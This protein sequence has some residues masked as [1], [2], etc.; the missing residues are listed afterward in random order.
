MLKI[1]RCFSLLLCVLCVLLLFGC[2]NSG[3]ASSRYIKSGDSV[4]EVSVLLSDSSLYT[5]SKKKSELQ[6]ISRTD[7]ASLYFGE[8]NCSVSLYEA[9]SGKLWRSLPEKYVDGA[10]CVISLGVIID[11][12][13]YTLDSQSDSL[14]F[15]TA[16]YEIRDNG[17]LVTY[18]FRRTIEDGTKLD[19]TVP[20]EFISTDGT[21]VA[22]IDCQNIIGENNGDNVILRSISLLPYFGSY[23]SGADGDFILLPDGCGL[24]LDTSEYASE[25]ESFSV[26]VYGADPSQNEEAKA[27]AIIPAFG[28]K[29]GSNSFTAVIDEGAEIA[30]VKAERASKESGYN[31]VYAEFEITPTLQNDDGSFYVSESTYNGK[32]KLSYRFLSGDNANYIGM[33]SA[34]RE[35]LIRSGDLV[36]DNI[37]TSSDYPFNLNLLGYGEVTDENGKSSSQVLCDFSQ[38][39]DILSSLKAKDINNINLRYKAVFEGG[40]MQKNIKKADVNSS[41]GTDKQL[42]ELC[43]YAL[44]GSATIYPDI[45][46]ITADSKNGFN[47]SALA[48]DGAET[49][50]HNSSFG[51]GDFEFVCAESI[52]DNTK[53]MLSYLRDS[54]FEGVCLSDAGS[55]LY[56]DFNQS[57]AAFRTDTAA[58]IYEQSNA[59]SANKKLMTN[60]GFLYSIKYASVIVGLPQY[61]S[62]RKNEGASQVPFIQAILHGISDYSMSPINLYS[63][64]T[65]AFLKAVEY[66]GIPYYEWYHTDNGTEEEKDSYYYMNSIAD[67]QTNYERMKAT[68]SDLRGARI[69]DHRQVEKNVYVTEYDG[70]TLIYVN[71]NNKAV[72][73][74][75]VTVD[76]KSFIR[77]N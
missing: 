17:V 61:A 30:T 41:L 65:N 57:S 74:S 32:I 16:S 54:D 2:G 70:S 56:S 9:G 6:Q 73:V 27:T 42:Q 75:G 10:P 24:T 72:T 37:D 44:S 28:L 23:S 43:D 50:L 46:L 21:M 55:V 47:S 8:S 59:V 18:S 4:Q 33:A 22:Q 7:M 36:T 66:G 49:A 14:G 25:K 29:K 12:K 53:S 51:E 67:A 71:Y 45:R 63:N 38:S 34:C 1:K 3:S 48:L 76:A 69:T 19:F 39:Y 52:S 35:L 62:Y 60:K 58:I 20:A 26:S 15:D 5:D 13:E 11:G 31:R 40:I 64:T 68:F 77:V